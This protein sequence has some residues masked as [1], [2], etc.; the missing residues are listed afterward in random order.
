MCLEKWSSNVLRQYIGGVA[1]STHLSDGKRMTSELRPRRTKSSDSAVRTF[2][3]AAPF[4]QALSERGPP[5]GQASL[6]RIETKCPEQ[7]ASSKPPVRPDKLVR[8]HC[9][10][11]LG[12]DQL[13]PNSTLD[14]RDGAHQDLR[15]NAKDSVSGND[16]PFRDLRSRHP[17][18][19][20]ECQR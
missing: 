16:M 13:C 19:Y 11:R 9:P 15:T 10:P 6:G 17:R 1:R 18:T 14:S 2:P 20:Y 12:S 7:D 3:G 5:F 8:V 4:G